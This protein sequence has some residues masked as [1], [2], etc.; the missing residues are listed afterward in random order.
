MHC[1]RLL[2]LFVLPLLLFTCTQDEIAQV[3]PLEHD[4]IITW[5]ALEKGDT[6]IT[7]TYNDRSQKEWLRLRAKFNAN[8]LTGAE[9]QSV[10][11]VSLWLNN[12][13]SAIEYGQRGKALQSITLLQNE[14]KVLRPR[15][16]IIHPADQLYEFNASWGRVQETCNDQMMCLLEWKEFEELYEQSLDYWKGYQRS[17]PNYSDAIFPGHGNN[18]AAA[19]AAAVALDQALNDFGKLLPASDH[20]ITAGPAADIKAMFLDYLAVIVAYPVVQ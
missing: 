2:S 3:G 5:L 11:R 7:Q 16:G 17:H 10:F 4:L 13:N 12:L 20:T 6:A 18:S 19:E 1:I 15:F 14:L 9:K 8:L